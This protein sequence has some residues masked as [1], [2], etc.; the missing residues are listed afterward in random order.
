MAHEHQADDAA[1]HGE[2]HPANQAEVSAL[3]T[4]GSAQPVAETEVVVGR[5]PTSTAE[6]QPRHVP[7]GQALASLGY[8]DFRIYWLGQLVSLI[9]TWMQIVGQSW[10][11]L[12]LSNSPIALGAVSALQFLPTLLLSVFGGVV[13][14]R[15]PRRQLLLAT[16][17]TSLLLALVLGVLTQLQLVHIV[18]VMILA[19]LLGV[20]NA[21]D[22]PTRQAFVVEM[23][24]GRALHNA[25]ALNSAAFNSARLIGPALAG[26]TIGGVGLAGAFYLNAASFLAAIASLLAVQAGRRPVTRH[27]QP[28]T[29]W[30]DL[31]EGLAYV[32]HTRRVWLIVLLVGIVG[33]FGMNN[34]VLIP[35]LARD[36][37]Q[38]G[39]A[40]FG[41]LTSAAGVGSLAAALFI[42][43]LGRR[44]QPRLL[45]A[46]A[47]LLGLSEIAIAA[48]PQL[49]PGLL[50]LQFTAD[51][52]L[53]AVLGAA[54]ILFTT[55]A[56]TT[57]QTAT[58]DALRGRVM[59]VYTTVFFGTTPIGSLFAGGLAQGWGVA[60][61]FFLGGLIS[62]VSALAAV[63]LA[64]RGRERTTDEHR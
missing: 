46:G 40:G 45:L 57:L 14:D 48:V 41:F 37:L 50:S 35:V 54:M 23:V 30:E 38:V 55:V 53:L 21:F 58:P 28:G 59:S 22:S 34:N 49:L 26:L 15:A 64:R 32:V 8:R 60:V 25:I 39:A 47:I 33:T 3:G 51:L 42:A 36:V 43:Y 6:Y 12:E 56:N 52:G 19:F 13:A 29:V 31:K 63:G 18:H 7:L 16:Q 62:V 5:G 27:V 4:P 11:V 2:N 9:G 17:S 10:L 44:A 1:G 20:V 61:P 24:G